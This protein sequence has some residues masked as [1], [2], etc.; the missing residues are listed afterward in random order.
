VNAGRNAFC[1]ITLQAWPAESFLFSCTF[2]WP[3][4]DTVQAETLDRALLQGLLEGAARVE[5]PPWGASIVCPAVDYEPG[6][7]YA[8][9]VRVATSLAVQDLVNHGEWVVEGSPPKDVA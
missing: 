9:A 8:L 7:R 5:Q 1:G 3:E 2:Q 6:A 4:V